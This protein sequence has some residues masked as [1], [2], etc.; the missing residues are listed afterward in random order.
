M[1]GGKNM[2]RSLLRKTEEDETTKSELG[3]VQEEEERYEGD[4]LPELPR[5]QQ[6]TRP[7]MRTPVP[8]APRRIEPKVII[9][10]VC[11][12]QEQMLNILNEKLDYVIHLLAGEDK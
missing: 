8:E 1:K 10:E 5:V 2:V 7:P 9:K 6:R 12:P 11:V 4:E 3:G